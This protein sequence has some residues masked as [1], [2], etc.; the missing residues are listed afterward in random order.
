MIRTRKTMHARGGIND[1]PVGYLFCFRFGI[2]NLRSSHSDHAR[3]KSETRISKSEANSNLEK[4]NAR[5]TTWRTVAFR[6]LSS[7]EHF[8][9]RFGFRISSFGFSVRRERPLAKTATCLVLTP[10]SCGLCERHL[11][12]R[13]FAGFSS[14]SSTPAATLA[15]ASPS[16]LI[17]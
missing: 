14:I 17:G 16:T 1:S 7:F 10:A 9:L 6:A 11:I 12:T 13:H 5:N 15:P 8:V 3:G 2:P 4:A